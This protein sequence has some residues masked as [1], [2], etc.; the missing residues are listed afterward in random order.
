VDDAAGEAQ[1]LYDEIQV[2]TIERGADADFKGMASVFAGVGAAMADGLVEVGR[3]W[4]AEAVVYTPGH[5]VGLVAARVLGVPAVLQGS[6]I[7]HPTFSDALDH[8][9]PVARRMGVDELPE[10]DVQIDVSPPSLDPV[11]EGLAER[12]LSNPT[13]T[14]GSS[15]P[16]LPMRFCS[17]AGGAALPRW[18]LARGSRP[19][20]ITTAGIVPNAFFGEGGLMGEIIAGTG[21]LGIE[22]LVTIADAEL[23]ALPSPLPEHV[24]PV[25]WLPLRALLA[26][27]DGI[28]HHGGMSTTYTSFA[29]GVPQLVVMPASH[30]T[31]PRRAARVP[32]WR[33]PTP[34]R[35]RWAR[36]SRSCWP[37]RRTGRPAASW[38]RRWR[39]CR[40]PA[41]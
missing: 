13:S 33:W 15:T 25:D 19:R 11:V 1:R 36:P 14:W 9:R 27:C 37:T 16:R 38:P 24:T 35:R 7:P 39:R 20:V 21:E 30:R 6:G 17:Y 41:P 29:A 23:S 4:G 32:G 31:S 12:G 22:L 34:A 10:A 28:I 18:V 26:T 40:S 5:A 3:A 2:L 8:L